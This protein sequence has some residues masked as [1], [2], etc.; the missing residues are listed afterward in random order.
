[1]DLTLAGVPVVAR[2][3][4]SADGLAILLAKAG[5]AR[6]RE[7]A[8]QILSRFASGFSQADDM[9]DFVLVDKGKDRADCKITGL[10]PALLLYP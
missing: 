1:V 2:A 8:P 5:V 3:F 9:F 6:G 4:A 10:F 7:D